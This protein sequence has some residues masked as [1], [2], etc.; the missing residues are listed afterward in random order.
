MGVENRYIYKYLSE[1]D[2]IKEWVI[3][4]IL[5]R[6]RKMDKWEV[7]VYNRNNVY[8]LFLVFLEMRKKNFF[9]KFID[10]MKGVFFSLFFRL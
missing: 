2:G 4:I 10:Y 5:G 9:L 1:V 7:C 3:E 6:I 8:L